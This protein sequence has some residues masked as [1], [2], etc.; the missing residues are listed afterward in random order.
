MKSK[1]YCRPIWKS[2]FFWILLLFVPEFIWMCS[3]LP[4]IPAS[5]RW[6]VILLIVIFGLLILLAG[7][8]AFHIEFTDKEVILRN[9]IYPFLTR[10]YAY[11]RI[12]SVEYIRQQY[13]NFLIISSGGKRSWPLFNIDRTRPSDRGAILD[14]FRSRGIDIRG[15]GVKPASGRRR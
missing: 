3:M 14:E 15:K 11:D 9:E 5:T 8:C 12:D 6:P 4:Q 13:F 1:I 10:T 2:S 7:V